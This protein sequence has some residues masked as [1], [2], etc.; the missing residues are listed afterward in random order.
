MDHRI[1]AEHAQAAVDVRD[2]VPGYVI[3]QL[4]QQPLGG[5][6]DP[7][8]VHIRTGARTDHHVHILQFLQH[9][10][11][12]AERV[13][14]VGIGHGDNP[15]GRGGYAGFQRCAVAAVAEMAQYTGTGLQRDFRRV[16]ARSVIDDDDLR[17]D[18]VFRQ[19]CPEFGE[20]VRDP[21]ALVIGRD[22]DADRL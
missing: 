8:D 11:Y 15:V 1:L 6:P 21:L 3:G 7:G 9:F 16:V 13:G 17:I 4:V 10:R 19:H 18:V 22:D 5:A 2:L 12:V 14:A 20:G